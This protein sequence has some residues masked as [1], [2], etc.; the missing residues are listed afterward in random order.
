MG[1]FEQKVFIFNEIAVCFFVAEYETSICLV[2]ATLVE[3]IESEKILNEK[4]SNVQRVL[5]PA[6]NLAF[7]DDEYNRNLS[8]GAYLQSSS[9]TRA[10][11]LV[12]Q[13][14]EHT[15]DGKTLYSY[16]SDGNGIDVEHKIKSRNDSGVLEF[17]V[18]VT[19]NSSI[20]KTIESLPSLSV[21]GISPIAKKND[22][23]KIRIYEIRNY[24][25]G[26]GRLVSHTAGE[27][28]LYNSYSGYGLRGYSIGRAGSMPGQ[29][30]I[31][32]LAIS[33]EK[34]EITWAVQPNELGSWRIDVLQNNDRIGI[35][36]GAGDFL[37]AHWR[38]I[39]KIGE[40]YSTNSTY[41]TC[42]NG[43]IEKASSA[44]VKNLQQEILPLRSE[45][46]LPHIFNEFL[47]S[48]GNP[49]IQNIRESLDTIQQLGFQYYVMDAGWYR[50]E[51]GNWEDI[52]DWDVSLESFPN[53]LGEFSDE[54][55][56]RGMIPGIW[57]EFEGF[58]S[59]SRLIKEHPEFALMYDGKIINHRGRHFL[60]FRKP[61]V[62]DYLKEKVIK[63]LKEY[64]IGYLKVDY[65][66]A[67]GIGADGAESYGEALRQHLVGV[68]SFF[69]LLRKEIPDLVLEMCSSGGM[70]HS[71]GWIRMGNMVS[72][73]DA[74][75]G[76]EGVPI[77][78]GLHRVIPPS[79]LQIWAEMQNR[80]SD[81]R[82]QYILSKAML[83]RI[84]VSGDMC[85][86]S[87]NKKNLIQQAFVF[88]EKI[89]DVINNG[90]T[91]KIVDFSTD[92]NDIEN[93]EF[94][95]VRETEEKILVYFF[96]T[97][98]ASAKREIVIDNDYEIETLWGNGKCEKEGCKLTIQKQSKEYNSNVV[99]LRKKSNTNLI[100]DREKIN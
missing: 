29:G 23:D 77:A 50:D 12:S 48:F 69:D 70:R 68:K 100:V 56:K 67:I 82:T 10:L 24:W 90:E 54:V 44:M 35:C 99:L 84:C 78:M 88:Y 47:Y 80:H 25:S 98:D 9:T 33:D 72:F 45:E 59:G 92:L 36:A 81:E 3:K 51:N 71:I 65:N 64:K 38:K 28:G 46:T 83:G 57:Y 42:V 14:E 94:W 17:S 74:H 2:P 21:G 95:L 18:K 97:G 41:V 63:P 11:K 60:D 27:L 76:K 30:H 8:S 93:K 34:E 13:K 61:E 39:L 58:S 19:N 16:F 22:A 75:F 79:M 40:S 7:S 91:V 52:G 55:R 37:S 85:N 49:N 1:N 6:V 5:M 53:G 32:F 96:E 26:E 66:E 31:P 87:E 43:G 73:S 62:I 15:L 89:K 20:D 4:A 86:L